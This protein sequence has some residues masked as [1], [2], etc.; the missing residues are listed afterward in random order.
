MRFFYSLLIL[1]LFSNCQQNNYEKDG[2]INWTTCSNYVGDTNI[3]IDL[4]NVIKLKSAIQN[5]C[6]GEPQR[7]V[8][9]CTSLIWKDTSTIEISTSIHIEDLM[10]NSMICDDSAILEMMVLKLKP[11]IRNLKIDLKKIVQINNHNFCILKY[12]NYG[13]VYYRVK[14]FYCSNVFNMEI[15]NLKDD[16]I[17]NAILN[18]IKFEDKQH[19]ICF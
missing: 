1:I 8:L 4:P 7:L 14:S 3:V 17:F 12:S 16:N 6:E 15:A 9:N 5:P 11:E 19:F 2:Q 10:E 13:A 18:S